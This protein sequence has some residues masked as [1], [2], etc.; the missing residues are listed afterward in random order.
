MLQIDI[1]NFAISL[2]QSPVITF[3]SFSNI[4]QNLLQRG[5]AVKGLKHLDY[6]TLNVLINMVL[7]KKRVLLVPN[8]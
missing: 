7:T 3:Q 1:L 8:K 4:F 5:L 6:G 2:S